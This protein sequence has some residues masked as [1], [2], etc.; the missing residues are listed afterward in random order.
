L[1]TF[2]PRAIPL[3]SKRQFNGR[4]QDKTLEI[5]GRGAERAIARVAQWDSTLDFSGDAL[6]GSGDLFT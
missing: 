1:A 3:I 6:F 2:S 5:V 4:L